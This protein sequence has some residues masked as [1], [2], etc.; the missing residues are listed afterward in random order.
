MGR[1]C[2]NNIMSKNMVAWKLSY[3]FMGFKSSL[4]RLRSRCEYVCVFVCVCVCTDKWFFSWRKSGKVQVNTDNFLRM[5]D[6]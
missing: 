1:V 6:Q 3:T 4:T 2:I 5:F